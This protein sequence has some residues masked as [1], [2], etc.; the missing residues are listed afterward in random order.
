MLHTLRKILLSAALVGLFA[1]Y[2]LQQ[3]QQADIGSP[4]GVAVLVPTQPS[5]QPVLAPGSTTVTSRPS[6][7]DDDE[8]DDREEHDDDEDDGDDDDG[9]WSAARTTTTTTTTT[10][11]ANGAT[12]LP[13][14][15]PTTAA[16]APTAQVPASWRD[17]VYL[18]AAANAY[19]G[20]VQVQVTIANGQITDVQ[21]VTYPDHR[22]RSVSINTRAM[23]VL[24]QEAIAAQSAQVDIVSGATDTSEA[25][26]HSLSTAL[27]EAAA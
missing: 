13:T 22:S 20:D 19:W 10:T 24:V 3:R 4:A 21:F 2:A 5:S 14:V 12:T 9:A 7:G 6:I 27:A 23:P 16:G 25:F 11:T 8:D 18:G 15:I 26:I 17:G 1:L